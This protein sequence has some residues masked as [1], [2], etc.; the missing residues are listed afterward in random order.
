MRDARIPDETKI[1]FLRRLP[2]DPLSGEGWGLR[3]YA[4]PAD[5]PSA[6]EDVYD[7]YSRSEYTGL[8]GVPYKE[9]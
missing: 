7:V 4:S 2:T 1:H 8:N 6:G 3:S 9:W 5:R